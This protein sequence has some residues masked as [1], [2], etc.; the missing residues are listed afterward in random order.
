MSIVFVLL[1]SLLS[2]SSATANPLDDLEKCGV[3]SHRLKV[4]NSKDPLLPDGDYLQVTGLK[5]VECDRWD[6]IF[7]RDS[8]LFERMLKFLSTK[9]HLLLTNPSPIETEYQQSQIIAVAMPAQS[10]GFKAIRPKIKSS[11]HALIMTPRTSLYGFLH[12][13]K[14]LGDYNTRGDEIL[15]ALDALKLDEERFKIV[16]DFILETAAYAA[17]LRQLK[18]SQREWEF[19]FW[20]SPMGV[21]MTPGAQL[22]DF[23]AKADASHFRAQYGLPARALLD[24]LK[25][26]KPVKYKP[27]IKTLARFVSSQDLKILN[28]AEMFPELQDCQQH[29]M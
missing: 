12:E 22:R 20:E 5:A 21:K 27:L 6:W 3:Q 26:Y 29:L 28:I 15:T 4:I 2:G 23:E 16:S 9:N 14:H 17:Q 8:E 13:L 11:S 19:I 7:L 10:V 25:S 18:T 1:L 24:F